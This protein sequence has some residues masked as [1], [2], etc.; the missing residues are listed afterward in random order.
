MGEAVLLSSVDLD[1]IARVTLEANQAYDG[2]NAEFLRLVAHLQDGIV[3]KAISCEAACRQRAGAS[4][5][6]CRSRCC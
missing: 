6:R 5:S 1:Q 4:S 3:Q 2:A